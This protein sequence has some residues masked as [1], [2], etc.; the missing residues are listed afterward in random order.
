MKNFKRL[1]AM[2]ISL[3]MLIQPFALAA[4]VSDF[5]DFPN[6]WSTEAMTAAVEN[7]LFIGNANK[8]LEPGRDIKRGEFAAFIVRAFGAT[9]MADIAYIEDVNEDD[10]FYADVARAYQM[11]AFNGKTDALF[12]PE[13]SIT[14]EEVF[15][16]LGRLLC[17]S[18]TD[19][20]VLEKFSDSDKISEFAK[21]RIIGLVENG[22]IDGY[23]DGTMR[24]LDYITRAEIAQL[25]H[26][27]FRTYISEPGTVTSVAVEGS[28]MVRAKDVDLRN[29]V[30]NGDLVIADGVGAGDFDLTGVTV[31]G[32]ILARGGEGTVT[33]KNVTVTKGVVICDRNGTVNFHNYRT[34]KP[35]EN[36]IEYT[37]ATFL[38]PSSG[39]ITTGG[40]ST[41]YT[42]TFHDDAY[43]LTE[44]VEVK[45][46]G[47]ISKEE[48]GN[49]LSHIEISGEQIEINNQKGFVREK[50]WDLNDPELYNDEVHS[51][52]Y[53]W[54]YWKN[55]EWKEFD[56]NTN[57]TGDMDVWRNSKVF[58]ATIK[59]PGLTSREYPLSF[60][61]NDE[62]RFV[63]TIKDIL[64]VNDGTLSE[65]Y[66]LFGDKLYK[67]L[68][69]K[70]II[71]NA[72]DKNIKNIRREIKLVDILGEQRIHDMIWDFCETAVGYDKCHDPSTK[73][74][75]LVNELVDWLQNGEDIK[76]SADRY[77]MYK[78]ILVGMHNF[79]WNYF[80]SKLPQQLRESETFEPIMD[81]LKTQYK[82]IYNDEDGVIKTGALYNFQE[83]MD[84]A[85]AN[86][87]EEY[88]IPSGA[89]IDINPVDDIIA[90]LFETTKL[91]MDKKFSENPYTKD[92]KAF[93][94]VEKWFTTGETADGYSGYKLLDLV[95]DNET[96]KYSEGNSYYNNLMA[97]T[98]ITDDWLNWFYDNAPETVN[99]AVEH[100]LTIS[101]MMV[102][103]AEDGFPVSLEELK[104]DA[105]LVEYLEKF[106][107][108]ECLDK[109]AEKEIYASV[110][111]GVLQTISS[112][113][114]SILDTFASSAPDEGFIQY[115]DEFAEVLEG[116]YK[117]NPD[118][119]V[120]T[121]FDKFANGD[122]KEFTFNG[123]T[124]TVERY[125]E[126]SEE[127]AN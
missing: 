21:E 84:L 56:E 114:D 61:Y 67:S 116:S 124:I 4:S 23:P 81:A 78:H 88:T 36:I 111:D 76:I 102:N 20:T 91:I 15:T 72:E 34:E 127:P 12:E 16:V 90:P 44:E 80:E 122:K 87:G 6:D 98:V 103:Y 3:I 75:K 45:N 8:L 85:N 29:V 35:F 52:E 89:Q 37:P 71:D 11:G 104:N 120:D 121:F 24:P 115:K 39:G 25:F 1:V 97:L 59:I 46:N 110:I 94:E 32:R 109:F 49:I 123:N 33:F 74:N 53:G 125:F 65:A 55:G 26:N 14:R 57:V 64:Y 18:G 47:K 68:I 63:D 69:D 58:K 100:I 106:G 41:K 28:V 108:I 113:L 42:V 96:G 30:I 66:G 2:I 101:D 17:V 10:W 5:L 50:G 40:G 107:L 73:E 27:I 119:T 77:F 31:N 112:K 70:D 93:F 60:N 118:F 43:G 79:S 19:E 62:V 48:L 51:V 9:V 83:K 7:G 95:V 38:K 117:D 105:D 126:L 99:T 13:T 22:Y 92:L 86:P 82:K 54:W